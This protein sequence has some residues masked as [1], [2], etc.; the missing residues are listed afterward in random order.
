[1]S[2]RKNSIVDKFADEMMLSQ[3]DPDTRIDPRS[4][5]ESLKAKKVNEYVFVDE[6]VEEETAEAVLLRRKGNGSL[7]IRAALSSQVSHDI[8]T[9]VPPQVDTFLR[10][11]M[12]NNILHVHPTSSSSSLIP[13]LQYQ[14]YLQMRDDVQLQ[15]DDFAIWIALQYKYEKPSSHVEPCWTNVFCRQDHKDHHDDDAR[16]KGESSAKKKR[17]S[18]KDQG[19][20]DDEVPTKEVTP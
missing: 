18:N 9:N 20:H 8:A 12:N 7:E 15:H 13:N 16:P 5:K 10:N 14:L 3:E 2:G 11:Y 1:M 19:T 6:E 4:H 17:T